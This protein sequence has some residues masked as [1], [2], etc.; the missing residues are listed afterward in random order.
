LIISTMV[1][2]TWR[3]VRNWTEFARLFDLAEH[4]FKQIALGVGIGFFKAQAIDQGDDLRE[5]GGLVNRQP[6]TGHEIHGGLLGDLAKEGKGFVAHKAH[7]RFARQALGP[8]RPAKAALGN[9]ERSG[10]VGVERVLELPIPLEDGGKGLLVQLCRHL[11][12]GVDAFDEVEEKQEGELLC[13]AHRIGIAATKK[14]IPD[15]V[16]LA[17]HI[18]G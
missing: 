18:V 11:V 3:G 7:Q 1:R 8:H 16:D 6:R 17:A 12:F 5:D 2:M 14:V 15:L 13:V 9:A 10:L 4:V